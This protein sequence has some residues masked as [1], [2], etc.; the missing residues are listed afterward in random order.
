MKKYY[1]SKR[2]FV[3]T[4]RFVS[5]FFYYFVDNELKCNYVTLF[6]PRRHEYKYFI[7]QDSN[8]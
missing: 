2:E 6:F 8:F 5:E 3:G 1:V 7:N 4:S